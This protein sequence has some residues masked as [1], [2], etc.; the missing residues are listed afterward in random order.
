VTEAAREAGEARASLVAAGLRL[1]AEGLVARS[2]GN[3]SLR[4]DDKT[5]AITPSGIPYADLREDMIVLVDIES[6]E[7][8]GSWKPSG[9][10]GLHR[11]IYSRRP[12]VKAIVHTHQDAASACAAA[13]VP[14]DAPW[15]TVPCAPYALPSTKSLVKATVRALGDRPAVLLANHGV[16]AVGSSI[17][18]AFDRTASLET[19]AADFLASRF[20]GTLPAKPDAKWEAGYLA[21]FALADGSPIL[22]STA[23]FTKA[24]A[25][26]GRSLPAVQDDLAQLVGVRVGTVPALPASCP[27]ASALFIQGRGLLVRGDD[28]EALAMVVEKAARAAICG[29]TIGGAVKVPAIE[30]LLM[31]FVY[32][33]SYAK[34]AKKAASLH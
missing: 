24:W 22:L 1:Q 31:H 8:S 9:E 17:A 3:L 5:M 13:R 33:Q 25:E 10:R 32:T 2:W 20:R 11:A 21:P 4:L 29:E 15:G 7:W 18:E 28:A 34:R 27:K 19:A 26:R 23:P 6:G 14:F 16:F 12:S 30:A